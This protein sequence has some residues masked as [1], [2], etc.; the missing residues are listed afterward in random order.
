[1]NPDP[2]IGTGSK[3]LLAIGAGI[4][5]GY[6]LALYLLPPVWMLIYTIAAFITL[7]YLLS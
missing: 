2:P 3:I 4:L 5:I 6:P 7:L 1:V